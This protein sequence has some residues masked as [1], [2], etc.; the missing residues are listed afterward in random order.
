ME[1]SDFK[2]GF[3]KWMEGVNDKYPSIL[4]KEFLRI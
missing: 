1:F 3:G 2:I 4:K